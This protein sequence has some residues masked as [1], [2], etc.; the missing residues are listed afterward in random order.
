M[1]IIGVIALLLAGVLGFVLF[2]PSASAANLKYVFSKG[3][4]HRYRLDVTFD[5]RAGGLAFGGESFKGRMEMTLSQATIAV[6]DDGVATIRYAIEKARVSE[7][8]QGLSVPI[9]PTE[10]TVKMAPDGRIVDLQGS[11]LLELGSD[12]PISE[13]SGMFGPESFGPILPD[14]R[15]D[16]GESW[17]IDE[18]LDNPFGEPFR[19]R[20]TGRL[21]ERTG[22]GPTEIAVIRTDTNTPFNL[23]FSFADLAGFIDEPLPAEVGNVRMKFD[24]FFKATMTQSFATESGFVKSVLGTIRMTGTIALSG[25]PGLPASRSAGVL[26]MTMDL[27]MTS[28]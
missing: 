24:G 25:V 19:Y 26:N 10:L 17:T 6:A 7:S 11:G 16:P 27:T 2:G 8:G 15:V 13:L 18:T 1:A 9:P 28:I 3:E 22:S 23:D 14:H 5:M 20:G 21:V 12:D 4:T